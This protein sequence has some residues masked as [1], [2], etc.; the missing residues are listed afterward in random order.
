VDVTYDTRQAFDGVAATYHQSNVDNPLIAAMRARLWRAVEQ[1]VP[2]GSHLLDLGCGPG[3]DGE[4]FAS[5][6]YRVTGIDAS[7]EMIREARSRVRQLEGTSQ[8]QFLPMP[9]EELERLAPLRFDAVCSDLGPLNCVPDLAGAARQIARRIRRGGMFVA[10]AIGRVCPWEIAL[11]AARR[12]WTRVRVR[13][14]RALTPVPLDG[15]TIWTRYYTPREFERVFEAAGFER[16]ERRALGLFVPPPYMQAFAT[17]HPSLIATLQRVDDAT[18]AWPGVRAW[19]D[20]FL[21]VM[22]KA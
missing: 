16:M 18:G 22:R 15:R 12:D 2:A 1:H 20:H 13:F 3:T 4:Y 8:V 17:R 11:Y 19:G 14:G 9:I 6:G 21:V 10:S 5:R 7:P